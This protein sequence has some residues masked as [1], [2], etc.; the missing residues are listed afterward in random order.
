MLLRLIL[1]M[2]S[3]YIS[4]CIVAIGLLIFGPTKELL[5]IISMLSFECLYIINI[6]PKLVFL[7]KLLI[8]IATLCF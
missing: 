8:I 4:F 6:N 3:E 2:H 5:K 7:L 1:H